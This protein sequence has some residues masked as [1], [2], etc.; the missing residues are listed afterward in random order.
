M[1]LLISSEDGHKK[2]KRVR[3]VQVD[4]QRTAKDKLIVYIRAWKSP[5]DIFVD[6][7]KI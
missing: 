4:D 1:D 6:K 2:V 3:I 7:K 5:V